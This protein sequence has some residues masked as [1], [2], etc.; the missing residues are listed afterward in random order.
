MVAGFLSIVIGAGTARA[1]LAPIC[2]HAIEM[3]SYDEG[4]DK[5]Y[6]A[7]GNLLE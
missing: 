4:H 7:D 1:V 5:E 2:N 3:S 6:E